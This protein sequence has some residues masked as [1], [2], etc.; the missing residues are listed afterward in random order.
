YAE[1]DVYDRHPSG[2]GFRGAG[3]GGRV[4]EGECR[5]HA[6]DQRQAK[7]SEE[8]PQA[9]PQ[10]SLAENERENAERQRCGGKHGR[11]R[12]QSQLDIDGGHRWVS[13]A[14]WCAAAARPAS[15][16]ISSRR[17]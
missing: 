10:G 14:A 8:E 12:G 4:P 15:A 2:W 13:T 11:E 6:D 1:N 16:V 9:G 7:G 5:H 17:K 3:G